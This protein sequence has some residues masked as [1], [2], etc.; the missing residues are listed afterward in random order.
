MEIYNENSC[1]CHAC[2]TASIAIAH[3]LRTNSNFQVFLFKK[4]IYKTIAAIDGASSNGSGKSQL[5]I[6]G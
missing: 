2:N 6:S 4:Y 1:H 5:K 3:A